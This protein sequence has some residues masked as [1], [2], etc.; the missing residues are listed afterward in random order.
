M[1]I[2]CFS[3]ISIAIVSLFSFAGCATAPKSSESART[4]T[5]KY[6]EYRSLV[7]TNVPATNLMDAEELRQLPEVSDLERDGWTLIAP[8]FSAPGPPIGDFPK[9]TPIYYFPTGNDVSGKD[10][11]FMVVEFTRLIKVV[12]L[13]PNKAPE[14]D[15]AVSP[16]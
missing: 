5:L 11:R 8:H 16:H 2:S 7:L 15:G 6:W 4:T 1:R 13:P 9:D 3:L 14:P 10:G 12:T